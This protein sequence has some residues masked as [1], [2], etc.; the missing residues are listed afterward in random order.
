[1]IALATERDTSAQLCIFFDLEAT[2]LHLQSAE[3]LEIGA[4]AR[5]LLPGN[6]WRTIREDFH[7]LVRPR[8]K[9]P[10]KVLR[11][12][13][14]TASR[15]QCEG[16]DFRVAL[17]AWQ[18]WL[19]RA[20]QQASAVVGEGNIVDVW[21]VAH[22][23]Q[24]YDLPLLL[25]QHAR[26]RQTDVRISASTLFDCLR[27][28]GGFVD[29]LQ[30]SRRLAALGHF[31][32]PSHKLTILH[33]YVVGQTLTGAHSAL[34][35][36][37]GLA[38]L[39]MQQPFSDAFVLAVHGG[40]QIASPAFSAIAKASVQ[41]TRAIAKRRRSVTKVC[42]ASMLIKAS[43]MILG[44]KSGKKR[45]VENG[46]ALQGEHRRQECHVAISTLQGVARRR[47]SLRGHASMRYP[48][49]LSASVSIETSS[50]KQHA[51]QQMDLS[52]A[53]QEVHQHEPI[54]VIDLR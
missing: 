14:L 42:K 28:L 7:T 29:T 30:L 19:Q 52:C 12:T 53:R 15:L 41:A 24:H 37:R 9:P 20:E 16:V 48:A 6:M 33:D 23:G 18:A 40:T 45:A 21:L 44:G 32:P 36:A 8:R 2:G 13:G 46:G 11:L 5:L 51:R 31:S 10:A 49:S 43:D 47:R 1:M 25:A 34:G 4:T 3:I 50:C 22:N 27:R 17:F 39:C 54:I 26:D 38:T 35:D